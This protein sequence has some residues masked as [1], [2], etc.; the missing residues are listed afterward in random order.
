VG[1]RKVFVQL[2]DSEGQLVAQDDRP[3]VLTGQRAA[4]TGLAVYGLRLPPTLDNGPYRLIAGIYNPAQP[5]APRLPTADG[6][7]HVVLREY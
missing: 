3:L 4:G 5:G 2:L 7:D 6:A 1:E